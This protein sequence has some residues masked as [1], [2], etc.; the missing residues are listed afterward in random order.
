MLVFK[1]VVQTK[2]TGNG[3]TKKKKKKKSE[4]KTNNEKTR[5]GLSKCVGGCVCVDIS[6]DVNK[7]VTLTT[8]MH[9]I[10]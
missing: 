3:F 1:L 6:M 4:K 2:V 10:V 7:S 9:F 5:H 8:D